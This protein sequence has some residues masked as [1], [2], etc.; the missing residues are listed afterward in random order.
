MAGQSTQTKCR[1]LVF[2]EIDITN[3]IFVRQEKGRMSEADCE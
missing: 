1:N 3:K 2:F